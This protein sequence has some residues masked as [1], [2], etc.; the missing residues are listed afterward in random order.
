MQHLQTRDLIQRPWWPGLVLRVGEVCREEI[1]ALC[2]GWPRYTS[3]SSFIFSKDKGSNPSGWGGLPLVILHACIAIRST[4]YPLQYHIHLSFH[5]GSFIH[6]ISWWQ[7]RCCEGWSQPG[8]WLEYT[9]KPTNP[10]WIPP[11][12][13]IAPSVYWWWQVLIVHL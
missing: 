11:L 12:G 6:S 4:D 5:F 13:V 9:H 7:W 1:T 2:T 8:I 10:F 3:A